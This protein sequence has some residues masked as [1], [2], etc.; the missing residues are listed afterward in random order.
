VNLV[1]EGIVRL[2]LRMST[3]CDVLSKATIDNA[4]E[5]ETRSLTFG[6]QEIVPHDKP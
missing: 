6:Q 1:G 4:L 5:S 3:L 2:G